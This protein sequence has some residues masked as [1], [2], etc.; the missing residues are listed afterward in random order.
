MT[1][2]RTFI[3]YALCGFMAIALSGNAAADQKTTNTILGAG[4]GAAAGALLSD[5]DPTLVLGGAAAGGLLGNVLTEDKKQYRRHHKRHHKGP[6]YRHGSRHSPY[7]ATSHYHPK[8]KKHKKSKKYKKH[9]KYK[10][11]HKINKRYR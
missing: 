1:L 7:Y 6:K 2:R 4:L 5:G 11:H 3:H 8:Y 9:R 10:K